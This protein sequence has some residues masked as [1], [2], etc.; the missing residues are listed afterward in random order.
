MRDSYTICVSASAS[1]QDGPA[2]YAW[3]VWHHDPKPSRHLG[4][5]S[6]CEI[7]IGVQAAYLKALRIALS[8]FELRSFPAGVIDL[9]IDSEAIRTELFICLSGWRER[10]FLSRN[11]RP[12]PNRDLW[13]DLSKRL[14]E[15]EQVGFVIRD[16]WT[17]AFEDH[18][19]TCRVR[20]KAVDM[21]Q[22]AQRKCAA[23]QPNTLSR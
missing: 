14:I 19:A 23:G 22:A 21:R 2:G 17:D 20:T 13:L 6:S 8:C 16:D 5:G 4:S 12:I 1:Q 18:F 7:S 11:L 15:L 3:D 9:R 10:D